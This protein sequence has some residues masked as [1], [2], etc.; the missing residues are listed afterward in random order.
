[1]ADRYDSEPEVPGPSPQPGG[2]RRGRRRRP[3]ARLPG[4][5]GRW[6]I[7]L[8]TWRSGHGPRRPVP[9]PGT[10][11]YRCYRRPGRLAA[12]AVTS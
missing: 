7:A 5:S 11:R 4:G 9:G 3:G 10:N 1:L 12:Q 8:G 6:F 2:V